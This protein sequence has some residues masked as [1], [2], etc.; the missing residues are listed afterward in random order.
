MELNIGDIIGF[1][2]ILVIALVA[3]YGAILFRMGQTKRQRIIGIII[4]VVDF[5]LM[6]GGLGV[7]F[8]YIANL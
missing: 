2:C 5:L 6:L 8:A 4:I 1:L 7:W 3:G